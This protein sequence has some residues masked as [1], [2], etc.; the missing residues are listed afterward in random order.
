M[1]KK[2]KEWRKTLSNVFNNDKTNK[3]LKR[4]SSKFDRDVTVNFKLID[5]IDQKVKIKSGKMHIGK[6]HT[7]ESAGELVEYLKSRFTK[8]FNTINRSTKEVEGYGENIT[9]FLKS[10]FEK[11]KPKEGHHQST[12]RLFKDFYIDPI[13]YRVRKFSTKYSNE[14]K[15]TRAQL[16]DPVVNA[17]EKGSEKKKMEKEFKEL[18]KQ[19]G[20]VSRF[21][22]KSTLGVAIKNIRELSAWNKKLK[23]ELPDELKRT[24][25]AIDDI[26]EGNYRIG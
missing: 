14:I 21:K 5:N 3:F 19:G 2:T 26:K 20:D 10:E 25:E 1:P 24:K 11:G 22:F 15:T 13:F 12:V 8:G 23:R 4:L 6:K 16:I 7:C 9:N 17:Y 18:I